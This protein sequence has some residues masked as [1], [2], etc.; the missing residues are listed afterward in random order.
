MRDSTRPRSVKRPEPAAAEGLALGRLTERLGFHLRLAQAAFYIDFAAVMAPLDLTQRQSAVL[1]MIGVNECVSQVRLAERLGVDRAT[2]M[3]IID[4]LEA[5]GLV[6]RERSKGDR[7]RQD[8]HLTEA[9]V[10]V[11][12]QL[13]EMIAVHE[14]HFTERFSPAELAALFAAL[15]RIHQQF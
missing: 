2:M 1:E 13:N 7:R 3:V 11:V 6:R 8:L 5:R 10:Q 15:K 12:A 14:R 4:R 9:G